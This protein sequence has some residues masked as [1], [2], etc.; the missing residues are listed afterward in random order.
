MSI[1]TVPLAR[2]FEAF[3]CDPETGEFTWRTKPNP[4]TVV[5]SRAG[6]KKALFMGVND[7][8]RAI[9]AAIAAGAEQ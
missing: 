2:L 3:N 9:A 7:F 5:G 1:R 8:R 6:T 4:H